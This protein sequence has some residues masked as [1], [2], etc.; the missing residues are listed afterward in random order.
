MSTVRVRG[1][2]KRVASEWRWK[3]RPKELSDSARIINLERQ[4]SLMQSH[5]DMI[6][7]LNFPNKKNGLEALFTWNTPLLTWKASRKTAS[8]SLGSV[9]HKSDPQSNTMHCTSGL[10]SFSGHHRLVSAYKLFAQPFFWHYRTPY[11]AFE[12]QY[13]GYDETHQRGKHV[14]P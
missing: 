13:L 8:S 11:Q 3:S 6:G 14:L 2:E 10:L 1:A 7:W 9:V 12:P 5:R 4:Q